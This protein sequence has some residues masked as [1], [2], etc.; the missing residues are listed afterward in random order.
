MNISINFQ[1][2]LMFYQHWSIEKLKE[3]TKKTAINRVKLPKML[4]YLVQ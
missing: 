3:T 1:V 2:H 4:H